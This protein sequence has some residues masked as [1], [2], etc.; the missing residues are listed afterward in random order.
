MSRVTA[1]PAA[2]YSAGP[3]DDILFLD[4][5]NKCNDLSVQS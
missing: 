4:I 1:I 2:P 3:P 5:P